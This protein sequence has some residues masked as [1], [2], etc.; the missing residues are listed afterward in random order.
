MVGNGNIWDNRT[1]VLTSPKIMEIKGGYECHHK[2]NVYYQ[3]GLLRQEMH[4]QRK[5]INKFKVR[6]GEVLP[7]QAMREILINTL[8]RTHQ[9]DIDIAYI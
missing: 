2:K 3:V 4:K 1:S 5:H 9:V 7:S 6:W 8:Q